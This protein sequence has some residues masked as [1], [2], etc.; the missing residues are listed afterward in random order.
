MYVHTIHTV[1]DDMVTCFV[2][3]QP[4]SLCI[5]DVSMSSLIILHSICTLIKL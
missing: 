3:S 1:S 5:S 2:A 4:T